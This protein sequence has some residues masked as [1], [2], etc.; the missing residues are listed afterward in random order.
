MYLIALGKF[1][2]I[3]QNA[4]QGRS[5]SQG[6]NNLT[7]ASPPLTT[8]C[9]NGVC[10]T[11]KSM[12][13]RRISIPNSN[14]A[15]ENLGEYP[16][17]KSNNAL[18]NNTFPS[19]KHSK[20][21]A[22]PA[23]TLAPTS[24]TGKNDS[25]VHGL[26]QTVIDPQTNNQGV[27][28][29]KT[30]NANPGS[31][32]S[33]TCKNGVCTSKTCVNGV[34]KTTVT[35]ST[36][37]KPLHSTFHIGHKSP[38][39]HQ[40]PGNQVSHNIEVSEITSKPVTKH[41]NLKSHSIIANEHDPNLFHAVSSPSQSYSSRSC[42]SGK[43]ISK[44]CVNG[45]CKSHVIDSVVPVSGNEITEADPK[46]HPQG[47]GSS[48]TSL[49]IHK[50][51]P[52][53]ASFP[54]QSKISVESTNE[55]HVDRFLPSVNV[56]GKSSYSKTC[57]NGHCVTKTCKN[58]TCK[59]I[60]INSTKHVS[61]ANQMPHGDV[62]HEVHRTVKHKTASG[63]H[64]NPV[65]IGTYFDALHPNVKFITQ[66]R[67]SI[68]QPVHSR[69]RLPI[70]KETKHDIGG[71]LRSNPEGNS[72]IS[73]I[74]S[75]RDN[76]VEPSSGLSH[77][78]FYSCQNGRCTSKTCKNGKCKTVVHDSTVIPSGQGANSF[79]PQTIERDEHTISQ[80]LHPELSKT[81]QITSNGI[82]QGQKEILP[83]LQKSAKG[84]SN[85]ILRKM[86][87]GS[88]KKCKQYKFK[89][90][91]EVEEDATPEFDQI[92]QY[93]D[94]VKSIP[95]IKTHETHHDTGTF[96]VHEKMVSSING[97]SSTNP[98]ALMSGASHSSSSS[99]SCENGNCV[100]KSCKNG[101]CN[102]ETYKSKGTKENATVPQAS[103]AVI[104]KLT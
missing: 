84:T 74:E 22:P 90:P 102:I 59:T 23:H 45:K 79:N 33:Y 20:F 92:T 18:D 49:T 17:P 31:H 38:S 100:S 5:A 55:N 47:L 89:T 71:V 96:P 88:C 6:S 93:Y 29:P 28:D 60:I 8:T 64:S 40:A 75:T 21:D 11:A 10:K 46:I 2:S 9:K 14:S 15:L 85:V 86:I 57:Q 27:S 48:S 42:K 98:S 66:N 12:N 78:S 37:Q 82:E 24:E 7:N 16:D 35:N 65:N 95:A 77:S 104:R 53:T 54:G 39:R 19:S 70:T 1:T 68:S 87:S 13:T 41:V 56:P 3:P 97:R 63:T 94:D 83:H 69:T 4:L 67:S 73:I 76:R 99:Y 30:S 81:Y 80:H 52:E 50:S 36:L 61:E 103:N 43:C 72:G 44:S 26:R 58:G 25:V 91:T 51:H 62:R 34:C 101:K 32:S